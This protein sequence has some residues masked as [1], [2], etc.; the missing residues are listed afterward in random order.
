MSD[1]PGSALE[2]AGPHIYTKT[3]VLQFLRCLQVTKIPQVL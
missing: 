2:N 1:Q 3:I